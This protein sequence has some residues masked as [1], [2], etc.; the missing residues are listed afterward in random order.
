MTVL[1]KLIRESLS[2]LHHE[3]REQG[4]ELHLDECLLDRPARLRYNRMTPDDI[5]FM[6][7]QKLKDLSLHV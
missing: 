5:I 2:P 7:G 6:L 4:E 3:S 1:D